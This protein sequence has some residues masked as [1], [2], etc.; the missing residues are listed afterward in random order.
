ME[1]GLE[2]YYEHLLAYPSA[3]HQND[4]AV[5]CLAGAAAGME[6][7]VV[8]ARAT[9][10]MTVRRYRQDTGVGAGISD[11][12]S[13]ESDDGGQSGRDGRGKCG[14][15]RL[16]SMTESQEQ[17]T[18]SSIAH[19]MPHQ[20]GKRRL[21]ADLSSRFGADRLQ[22]A[23]FGGGRSTDLSGAA[24]GGGIAGDGDS[25]DDGVLLS[26]G[27]DGLL[28]LWDWR[29]GLLLRVLHESASRN[30]GAIAIGGLGLGMHAMRKDGTQSRNTRDACSNG[31]HAVV[32]SGGEDG[33]LVIW[34]FF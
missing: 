21:M 12:V 30:I 16:H 1:A 26:A 20:S 17:P 33:S 29:S 7:M 6:G 10:A 27:S 15:C 4:M 18:S 19:A 2:A 14:E 28:R 22:L 25:E 5:V 8:S 24:G 3:G 23:L 32:F 34:R 13:P 9:G 11:S 31:A